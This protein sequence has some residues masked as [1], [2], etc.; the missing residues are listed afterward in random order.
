MNNPVSFDEIKAWKDEDV[1]YRSVEYPGAFGVLVDRY[2]KE[3]LRKVQRIVRN[4]DDAE[5]V[6]QDAFVKIYKNAHTFEV[7]EGAQ[8]SSWAYKILLNT[9]FTFCKKRKREQQ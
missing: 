7:Q 6:V 5:D 3:F 9:C 1:L 8:F 4:K 2:Q